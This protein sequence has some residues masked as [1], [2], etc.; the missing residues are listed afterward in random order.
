[1]IGLVGPLITCKNGSLQDNGIPKG[2]A[3]EKYLFVAIV[4][5]NESRYFDQNM[6]KYCT[7]PKCGNVSKGIVHEL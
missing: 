4:D 6:D 7:S 5:E 2:Y 1:M 3:A